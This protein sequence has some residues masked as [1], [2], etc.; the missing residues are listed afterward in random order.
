MTDE[1][2]ALEL[3]IN[4]RNMIRVNHHH[5]RTCS[6]HSDG[7]ILRK[8]P[9]GTDMLTFIVFVLSCNATH[10]AYP[11]YCFS[12]KKKNTY[13]LRNESQVLTI[14]SKPKEIAYLRSNCYC[15]NASTSSVF[16]LNS[17]FQKLTVINLN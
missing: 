2:I 14:A 5:A 9:R 7:H 8:M 13:L 6:E 16:I 12:Q 11:P 4:T 3:A 15:I 1:R 10:L 17:K